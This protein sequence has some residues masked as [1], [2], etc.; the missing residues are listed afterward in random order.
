MGQMV[1][2]HI[3]FECIFA[4]FI[5]SNEMAGKHFPFHLIWF[6]CA[7]KV[8]ALTPLWQIMQLEM[9]ENSCT[10][11]KPAWEVHTCA[12]KKFSTLVNTCA[13]MYLMH[14]CT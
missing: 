14:G 5:S 4:L 13:Y 2:E 7:A 12:K 3:L 1:K 9:I 11:Y 10:K 6:A 8:T